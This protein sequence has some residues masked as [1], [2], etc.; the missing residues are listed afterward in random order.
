M[1][2]WVGSAEPQPWRAS[3]EQASGGERGKKKRAHLGDGGVSSRARPVQAGRLRRRIVAKSRRR[4]RE[5]WA[6]GGCS[7]GVSRSRFDLGRSTLPP[8]AWAPLGGGG[9]SAPRADVRAMGACAQGCNGRWAEL[10]RGAGLGVGA[11]GELGRARA[12][13]RGGKAGAVGRAGGGGEKRGEGGGWGGPA[14][15]KGQG[16]QGCGPLYLFLLF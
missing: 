13:P 2:V 5:N 7:I 16:E 4:G 11:V 15:P 8:G 9:G 12:G 1:G 14:G 10:A 3:G 6:S